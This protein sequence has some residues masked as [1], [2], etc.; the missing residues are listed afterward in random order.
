MALLDCEGFSFSTT[1]ADYLT[2]NILPVGSTSNTN[3]YTGGPLG[4]NYLDT[5][6][7]SVNYKKQ[8]ASP[9]TTFYCGV[10]A[11]NVMSLMVDD[12]SNT[13]QLSAQVSLANNTIS[14]YRNGTLL[15]SV[16]IG[17][18]ASSWFY[19]ELGGVIASG[20]GG[21]VI[22]RL[23]GATIINLTGQNTAGGGA[24]NISRY[25]VQSGAISGHFQT[26]HWYLCDGTG[27][28][29]WNTFLG[30]I[31]VQP[32][33]PTSNDVVQFTANGLASQYL[34]AAKNPPVPATDYNS[35]AN[36]GDQDTFN[37]NAITG[38]TTQT[39]LGLSV[40][41]LAAKSDSGLKSAQTVL[42]SGGTT[43]LGTSTAL[44]TGG[45]FLTKMYPT[46]P[47]TS[48]AWTLANANAAKPG[49]KVSA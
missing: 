39:V 20:T 49:Y 27:P 44:S 31:R 12:I 18:L 40:K 32:M 37:C 14:V 1:I 24:N 2:Y 11:Q 10:R 48:A 4:D 43:D 35:D 42:K 33:N 45:I 38:V 3:I 28:A 6:N 34:N 9:I 8:I 23:N 7:S 15:Q 30:D 41:A 22:V 21:S 29:P 19:L 26:S 47:N 25:G 36:V 46:D 5:I 13:N 17:Y 16:F